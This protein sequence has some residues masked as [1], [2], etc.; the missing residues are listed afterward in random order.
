MTKIKIYYIILLGLM[1]MSLSAI[2]QQPTTRPSEWATKV[3]AT[4]LKNLYKVNDSIY[5]CEQ[6]DSLGFEILNKMGVMSVL[7]LRTTHKDNKLKHKLPIQLYNVKMSAEQITDDDI[8]RA[9]WILKNSPK[10]IVVHCAHGS[11]RTGAVLAMYRIV[12][13]NWTKEQAI[14][15]M[16]KGGYGFHKLYFNIAKYIKKVD[17]EKIKKEVY[18]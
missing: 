4:K 18:K 16:K 6:P 3:S 8:I 14:N 1:L 2:T 10:P 5:R 12:F 15:E 11:D 7:N 13:Q 17:V 9:L